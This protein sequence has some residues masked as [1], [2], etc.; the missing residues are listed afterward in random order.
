M[1][2]Y[3]IGVAIEATRTY[4]ADRLKGPHVEKLLESAIKELPKKLN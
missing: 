1:V 2:V 4:L 3:A